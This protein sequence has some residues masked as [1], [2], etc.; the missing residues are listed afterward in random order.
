MEAIIPSLA[1]HPL[2]DLAA[3]TIWYRLSPDSLADILPY[4]SNARQDKGVRF[5][6]LTHENISKFTAE[7]RKQDGGP[8][9]VL[10][11]MLAN[12]GHLYI[13]MLALRQ[14]VGGICAEICYPSGT[15]RPDG[16]L[17]ITSGNKH[18]NTHD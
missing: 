16:L 1:P 5:Y 13:D 8:T 9:S 12:V 18:L 4:L 6:D 7:Q 10:Y 2:D 3:A 15:S 17:K 11:D 14:G